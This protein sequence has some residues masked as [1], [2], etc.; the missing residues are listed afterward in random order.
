MTDF[1]RAFTGAKYRASGGE[2]AGFMVGEQGP[3]MFI[4]DRAGRI[5]P[6]DE[7]ANMNNAPTNI[8]FSI[9]A[10]DSQGVEELLINQKGNIIKMIREAANE[11]GEF[12]L[13]A[14][15]EKTY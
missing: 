5:A 3:E 12:F 2:T 4:P 7:T 13:E 14:V 9:S 11:H 15:Q 10:V 1:T 6:A 8:N